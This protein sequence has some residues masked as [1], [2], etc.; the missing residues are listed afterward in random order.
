MPM[1]NWI[2]E[3]VPYWDAEKARILGGAAPGTFPS[4][5]V[6]K[7]GSEALLPGDWWRV[8]EPN[9]T[10]VGYAWMDVTWGDAEMLLVVDEAHRRQGYGTEILD[11]LEDEARARGLNYLYN[12]VSAEHPQRAEV[13]AWLRKRSFLTADD[14]SLFRAVIRTVKQKAG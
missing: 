2:H 3:T 13:T 5:F 10:V 9:G 11:N 4:G 6:P 14:G 1:L 12:E 7:E 8:E